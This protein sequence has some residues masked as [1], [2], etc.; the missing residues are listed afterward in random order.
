[1]QRNNNDETMLLCFCVTAVSDSLSEDLD[2]DQA[3]Q[4]PNLKAAR[5]VGRS[6][7]TILHCECLEDLNFSASE[8]TLNDP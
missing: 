3:C 5:C 1:M 7:H 2:D 8:A 4:L 6:T